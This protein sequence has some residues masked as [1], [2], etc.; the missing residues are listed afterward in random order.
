MNPLRI[1]LIASSRFPVGEPFAGGLE[2]HTHAL[3]RSLMARGHEVTLFAA[4]GS[5]PALGAR[6]LDVDEFVS[7]TRA[8][9]DVGATPEEWI[10]DHHAYLSLML[11]LMRDGRDRFDIV[12][13]N[14][15]HHLPIAMSQG[16][17]VPFV[18][19]LHTPP[20]PW[21][22]SAARHAPEGSRFVAVSHHTASLWSH[23]C[24]TTVLHNG[25]DL[26]QWAPGPGSGLAASTAIWFGRIVPEKGVH[27]AMDAARLAAMP[28][29]IAGPCFDQAYFD[30]QVAPRLGPDIR[31]LGH[32][33]HAQLASAVGRAAV[34]VVTPCWDEPYGLVAAESLAC[35][36]PV[37]AF[38]RGALG[39]IVTASSGRLA[40]AGDTR[41][42]AAAML[43]ARDI[44]R[45]A[46]VR[47]AREACSVGVMVDGY[48]RLYSDMR[49]EQDA[50]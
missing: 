25:V 6:Y 33:D 20:T 31:Y 26:L 10:R 18:T 8:R 13:N 11:E 37:A 1:C 28:L 2:A 24:P 30:E 12:H 40:P 4:P 34:A 36:T 49:A 16:I 38:D 46:A 29:D 9:L 5:D 42:L 19:T 41:A 32:L 21:I 44:P 43:E 27:F 15:L 22:E 45:A 50:A 39:E 35:G 48:E 17:G 7:S 47:R 3:A 14:S 23:V